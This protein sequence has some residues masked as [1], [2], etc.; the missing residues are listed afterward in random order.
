M[1]GQLEWGLRADSLCEKHGG[2]QRQD[3][4][5]QGGEGLRNG[6]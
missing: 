4:L 5:E 1:T 2:L 6:T 3:A